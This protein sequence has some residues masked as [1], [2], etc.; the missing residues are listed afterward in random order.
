MSCFSPV[1]V[2]SRE[3]ADQRDLGYNSCSQYR[4]DGYNACA[5]WDKHCCDWWPC[6]WACKLITWICQG[7]YWVTNLVCDIWTWIKNIVCLAWVVVTTL[8]CV[9]LSIIFKWTP[10]QIFVN[11]IAKSKDAP[12]IDNPDEAKRQLDRQS[13]NGSPYDHLSLGDR[14]IAWLT[15]PVFKE[16]GI[17]GWTSYPFRACATG[18]VVQAALNSDGLYTVDIE[19]TA[20]DDSFG[21]QPLSGGELQDGIRK[22]NYIRAEVFPKVVLSTHP[23]PVTGSRVM[24]CGNLYWDADGFLEIHPAASSDI[25]IL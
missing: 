12:L 3:C 22:P 13:E 16:N 20:D 8:V 23:L 10:L 1:P 19:I 21:V 24:I 2:R 4:D 11:A 14:E 6:S 25:T 9:P 18:S 15:T 17:S 5:G 7:W